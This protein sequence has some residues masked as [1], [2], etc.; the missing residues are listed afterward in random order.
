MD[1]STYLLPVIFMGAISAAAAIGAIVMACRRVAFGR[2]TRA[3]LH[4]LAFEFPD[5]PRR[6][7]DPL[8]EALA[9]A[10]AAPPPAPPPPPPPPP[11]RL[12]LALL[13]AGSPERLRI[14]VSMASGRILELGLPL[15]LSTQGGRDLEDVKLRI[16]LP[17]EITY[18]ASL[19]RMTGAALGLPGARA[20]YSTGPG[21][22]FIDISLPKTPGGAEL[23]IP[24]PVCIKGA[25]IG[26]HALA[27]SVAG[28]G[29]E[30]IERA[31]RLEL[32]A[33]AEGEVCELVETDQGA[34]WICRPDEGQRQR[35]PRL[36]LDRIAR[37]RIE[38]QP[39]R[40][41]EPAVQDEDPPPIAASAEV[42]SEPA[43]EAAPAEI[44]VEAA[45]SPAPAEAS[46]E[47]IE[48]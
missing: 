40:P 14:P 38:D 8:P 3:E 44:E 21:Q 13:S 2:F 41:A 16:A 12:D 20:A 4:A 25:P 36:P 46:G 28:G 22:T 19:D 33:Q 48:V 17:T 32:V 26:D 43:T 7:P 29:L 37:F 24:I 27:I 23:E 35:D 45:S 6:A 10:I 31:Y 5:E 11:A 15:W 30:P 9:E 34:V 47:P 42:E 1:S 39:A 18:G